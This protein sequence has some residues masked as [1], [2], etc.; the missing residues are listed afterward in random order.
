[1]CV[2]AFGPGKRTQ[3]QLLWK[4]AVFLRNGLPFPEYKLGASRQA[5]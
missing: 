4:R 5:A 3:G 1:M 2:A